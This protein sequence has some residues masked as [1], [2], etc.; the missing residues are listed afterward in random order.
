MTIAK[1]KN[2]IFAQNYLRMKII[3]RI[4][5]W[6]IIV[7][8]I[9]VIAVCVFNK[10]EGKANKILPNVGIT[11][12][13]EVFPDAQHLQFLDTS[14][15]AVK[16][17][18]KVTIGAV[19]LSS[20]YSDKIKGYAGRTPL[21]IALGNDG[22]IVKI[23]MLDNQ[24]TPG[25]LSRVIESGF[26]DS[27]NGLTVDEAMEKDVDAVSGAT[28]SSNSI[29]GSLKA[30]LAVVSR[31]N[32]DELQVRSSFW[33]SICI[34]IVVVMALICFFNYEKL[35][36]LRRVT[37]LLSIIILGFWRNASM[38]LLKYFSWL[39]NGI[40]WSLEW[41]L[42][43]IFV[44]SVLLPLFTG[45]AF[46]CTYLCPMGALQE[47]TGR[48]C[49]KKLNLPRKVVNVLLVIRKL[50]LLTILIL[51]TVGVSLN[52]AFVEPFSVFSVKSV[53]LFS[54]IFAGVVLLISFF[55][56]R[57]WCR[58]LCPTGLL[59]ELV[60]KIKSNFT[61]PKPAN[62]DANIEAKAEA[63]AK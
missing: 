45:K 53:T 40:S 31:Q 32:V 20:P 52:L 27:W 48:I 30:R 51:I 19:L 61:K 3:D 44:F 59:F 18:D 49:S 37:L 36:I 15:Y 63:E 42:I 34:L 10:E 24:E 55:I 58:F 9:A 21:L 62:A 5:N 12:I 4:L 16:N 25:F 41:A 22:K 57:A 38:S 13:Q 17:A 6:L 26:L 33:P 2:I 46:Y 60:R 50:F 11:E 28:F 56:K 47:M 54:V 7:A 23:K 29:Q 39:T 35:K 43:L 14:Y 1:D 8:L